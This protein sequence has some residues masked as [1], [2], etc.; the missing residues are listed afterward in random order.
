VAA[1]FGLTTAI[2]DAAFQSYLFPEAP[3]LIANKVNDDLQDVY[4]KSLTQTSSTT[5]DAA[6]A[7]G[8]F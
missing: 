3:G 4:Q 8:A 5:D 1:A 6:T 2:N 7:R